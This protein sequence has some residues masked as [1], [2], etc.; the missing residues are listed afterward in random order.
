MAWMD[1]VDDL[2][3]RLTLEEIVA[4]T[5]AIYGTTVP[6]IPRYLNETEVDS[7]LNKEL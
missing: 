1:R 2:V 3:G 4:Q 7:K 5:M 6:P